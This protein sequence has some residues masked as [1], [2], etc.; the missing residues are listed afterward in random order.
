MKKRGKKIGNSSG[1]EQVGGGESRAASILPIVKAKCLCT[2]RDL[3]PIW[4]GQPQNSIHGLKK[5]T[6]GGNLWGFRHYFYGF[7]VDYF[8]PPS[9][10]RSMD[11][12]KL[13]DVDQNH[14]SLLS[15][16]RPFV[17]FTW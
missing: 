14:G 11:R 4:L 13:V 10:S 16:N 2:S 15:P 1:E 17:C 12:Q 3:S 9:P 8:L 5:N 6:S 7:Y